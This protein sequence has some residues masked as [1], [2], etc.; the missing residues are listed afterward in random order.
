MS[1]AWNQPLIVNLNREAAQSTFVF[2]PQAF[3]K[4]RQ[5]IGLT[6]A[7]HYMYNRKYDNPACC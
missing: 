7:I 4:N 2:V 3:Q 6:A 5:R 1:K